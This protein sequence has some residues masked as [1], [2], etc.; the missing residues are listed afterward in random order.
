M[1]NSN[2]P[3]EKPILVHQLDAL[4]VYKDIKD[5]RK[6]F[7]LN[8]YKHLSNDMR[9]SV[10]TMILTLFFTSVEHLSKLVNTHDKDVK[11]QC[12]NAFLNDYEILLDR[13]E[14]LTDVNEIDYHRT[15]V[16]FAA[17]NQITEQ[18]GSFRKALKNPISS[19]NPQA[20]A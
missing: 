9:H 12:L 19:Q 17:L 6:Y 10:G 4:P 3:K 7:L 15:A 20:T 16:L 2:K 1:A 13:I 18:M 5:L 8:V 14:F 11:I